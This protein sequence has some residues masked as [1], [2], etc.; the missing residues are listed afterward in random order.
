MKW[1]GRLWLRRPRSTLSGLESVEVCPA[2]ILLEV[3]FELGVFRLGKDLFGF[4][5][6]GQIVEVVLAAGWTKRLEQN[7][8]EALVTR[9]VKLLIY[10]VEFDFPGQRRRVGNVFRQQGCV[11]FT[12]ADRI[13]LLRKIHHNLQPLP[14]AD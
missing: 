8:V 14:L 13:T 11:F 7:L 6:H 10:S 3:V 4:P 1:S 9:D 12:E 2:W 5:Q